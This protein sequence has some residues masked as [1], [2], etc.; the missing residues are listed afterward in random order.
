MYNWYTVNT[1]K[2]CP[3][4]WHVPTNDEITQLVNY[5]GGASVAGGILKGTG[6]SHWSSPNTG[7]TDANN[8]KAL[9]GGIRYDNGPF[10]LTGVQGGWWNSSNYST[11]T[12]W[13]LYLTYNY[14]N[15]FQ[16]NLN[17]KNGMSVRC[18]NNT[19]TK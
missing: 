3:V 11:L 5:L 15:S 2:L 18:I 19:S 6:T 7:A 9:P 13:Y 1:G 17:K 16:G 4:G 12:A 14:S 8:F 10:D